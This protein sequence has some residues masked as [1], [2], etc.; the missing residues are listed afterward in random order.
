MTRL[1]RALDRRAR[2]LREP[3]ARA[4]L[5]TLSRAVPLTVDGLRLPARLHTP[6]SPPPWPGVLLVPGGLDGHTLFEGAEAVLSAP[7]L[8]RHGFAALCF[9]PSGR[10]G[11]PGE[12][13]RNGPTHQAQCAAALRLLEAQPEVDR[14]AVLSVSFGA[15][16]VAGA[17]ADDPTLAA[18][19]RVWMDWEGPGSRRWFKPVGFVEPFDDE[20]FWGPREAARRMPAVACPYHRIQSAWDHVW[21][22][23]RAIGWEMVTAVAGGACPDVRLNGQRGPFD[24]MA[25]FRWPSAMELRQARWMLRWLGEGVAAP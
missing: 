23:E 21:G 17:L 3:L 14:V 19:V 25:R 18:R 6:T 16:M 9:S 11:A 1:L 5:P 12:E 20:G 4:A 24:D 13:D 10:D 8:A 22:P 7:R 15:V 2:R